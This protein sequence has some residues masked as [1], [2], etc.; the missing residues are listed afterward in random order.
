VEQLKSG[1]SGYLWNNYL[2]ECPFLGITKN[3]FFNDYVYAKGVYVNS[4]SFYMCAYL[5]IFILD[6]IDT[7]APE[8]VPVSLSQLCHR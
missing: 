2:S 5:E 3:I 7:I 6:T 8:L 4:W 1:W